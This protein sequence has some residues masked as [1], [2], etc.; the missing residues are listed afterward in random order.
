MALVI[1]DELQCLQ[2]CL[3]RYYFCNFAHLCRRAGCLSVLLVSLSRYLS[4]I[5]FTWHDKSAVNTFDTGV[6]ILTLFLC[7]YIYQLFT[8]NSTKLNVQ[9]NIHINIESRL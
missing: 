9:V 5:R 6:H 7:I 2:S 3:G 8:I 4:K 1:V